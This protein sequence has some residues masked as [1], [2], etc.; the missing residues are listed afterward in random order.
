MISSLRAIAGRQA[1]AVFIFLAAFNIITVLAL[2]PGLADFGSFHAAGTAA[3]AGLNP[4]GA[5][6]PL[7]FRPDILGETVV[8][9]NLNPPALLPFC[10][11]ISFVDPQ[12]GLLA[13]RLLS[14]AC[15]G[16]AVAII[17]RAYPRARTLTRLMWS[18]SIA[19]IYHILEMGQIYAP[20]ALIAAG[21]YIAIDRKHLLLG[22]VLMG[23]LVAIKPNLA[24]WPAALLLVGYWRVALAAT[25]PRS[26][27]RARRSRSGRGGS[28]GHSHRP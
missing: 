14:L 23:V 28:S 27:S 26:A 12:F 7:I 6:S 22:G 19:G 8:A 2:L 21:A 1:W 3:R 20:L 25:G 9:L 13:W 24:I 18:I 11:I 5:D 16:C 15:Y 10:E 4:Y 17:W